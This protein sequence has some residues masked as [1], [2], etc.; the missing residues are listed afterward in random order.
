MENII[1]VADAIL[2]R[3]SL[4]VFTG[5]RKRFALPELK[6]FMQNLGLVVISNKLYLLP[7]LNYIN[8]EK[9]KNKCCILG[10][11]M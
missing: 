9:R 5:S 1:G 6:S 11:K 8:F 3:T 10:R 4:L 2:N 7:A